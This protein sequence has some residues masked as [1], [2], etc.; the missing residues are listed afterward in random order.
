MKTLS[1]LNQERNL[2]R[3][4]TVYKRKQSKAALNKYGGGFWGE[5]TTEHGTFHWRKYYYALW[6][7]IMDNIL[8]LSKKN[9]NGVASSNMQLFRFTS[10]VGYL[11]N[12]VMFLSAVWTLILTAPIHCRVIPLLVSKWWNVTFLQIFSDEET[13]FSTSWMDWGGV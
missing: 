6:T 4:S 10:C 2:H 5:R 3:S 8:V 11:W 9:L 7:H 13:N 12:I 1:R